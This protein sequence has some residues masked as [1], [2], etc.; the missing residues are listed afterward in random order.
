MKK[1]I[2]ILLVISF[3][4]C[5]KE[6]QVVT[7]PKATK[8][9]STN[10][11]IKSKI[12]TM[13]FAVGD[14]NKDKIKDS[15]FVFLDS[16]KDKKPYR[17]EIYFG[18]NSGFNLNKI[19]NKAINPDFPEGR[20][21]GYMDFGNFSGIEIKKGLLKIEHSYTRGT[22]YHTY[23]YQNNNF[24]L[25]GFDRVV[26]DGRETM[27]KISFNLNT[28]NY[29]IETIGLQN[30]SLINQLDTIIKI[31]PLPIIEKFSPIEEGN[32]YYY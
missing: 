26:S 22:Q 10:N 13:Y 19:S 12:D 1:I 23:R 5:K 25:I 32:D 9:K 3:S 14:L 31:R 29:H 28:G 7:T 16:L 4:S 30:D 15:V 27:D 6:K 18:S 8:T 20:D 17:L 24:E 2:F 21:S 11:S